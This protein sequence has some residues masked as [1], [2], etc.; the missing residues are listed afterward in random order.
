MRV[1]IPKINIIV[2][3]SVSMT[4]YLPI[5]CDG[6]QECFSSIKDDPYFLD[7]GLD[8]YKN[9]EAR[10]TLCMFSDNVKLATIKLGERPTILK[11][12]ASRITNLGKALQCMNQHQ[13]FNSSRLNFIILDGPISDKVLFEKEAK[14]TYRLI[15]DPLEL[16]AF[17]CLGIGPICDITELK[18]LKGYGYALKN[19]NDSYSQAALKGFIGA[20]VCQYISFYPSLGID[21]LVNQFRP[22]VFEPIK[23][24]YEIEF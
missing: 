12:S 6:I 13:K 11:N 5:I 14:D 19:I 10:E 2:D 22:R 4:E 23:Q 20:I 21:P 9:G 24:I 1:K 17:F 16:P 18:S 7:Y 15:K 8:S 3:V